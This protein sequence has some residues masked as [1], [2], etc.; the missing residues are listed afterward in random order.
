VHI[1]IPICRVQQSP[2]VL[3][4]TWDSRPP[5]ITEDASSIDQ[6]ITVITDLP[7]C[8]RILNLDIVA[9]SLLVP[10]RAR[11][12]VLGFHVIMKTVLGCKI[13]EIVI[14]LLAACVYCRPVE[15]RFE[16]PGVVMG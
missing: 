16:G 13:I 2:L 14:Y 6:D 1:V 5:P 4:Q 9:A 11:N 8:L 7:A 3:V 10:V 15:L 12:L